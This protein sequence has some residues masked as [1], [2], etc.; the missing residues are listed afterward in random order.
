MLASRLVKFNATLLSSRKTSV[1]FLARL[2]DNDFRTVMGKN[3]G[4]NRDDLLV[5]AFTAANVK[6]NLEVF[7]CP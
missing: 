1:Q 2:C 4:S 7:S 3:M 5:Q 6:K